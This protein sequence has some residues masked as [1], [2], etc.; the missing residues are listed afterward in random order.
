MFEIDVDVRWLGPLLADEPFEQE[1]VGLRVDARYAEY[2][3]DRAVCRRPPPLAQN[4]LGPRETDDVKDREE[5]RGVPHCLDELKFMP[6][7]FRHRLGDTFGIPLGRPLPGEP[8]QRRLDA[9]ARYDRLLGILVL[10]FAQGKRAAPRDLDGAGERLGVGFEQAVH[11]LGVLEIS[12]GMALAVKTDVVDRLVM[13]DA[14]DD[15]LELATAGFVEK[16]VVGD[17]RADAMPD[18]EVGQVVDAQLVVRPPSQT[19]AH[20]RAILEDFRHLPQLYRACVVGFVRN[21][22]ADEALGIKSDIV[23]IQYAPGLAAARLPE[24]QQAAQARIGR[25]I[26]RIDEER[27]AIGEIE[28]TSDDQLHARRFRCF[29][30]THDPRQRIPVHDPQSLD[31][32]FGRRGEQFVSGTGTSKEGEVRCRLEFDVSHPKIPWRNQRCDPVAVSTP[33]PCR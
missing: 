30:G 25:P 16:G 27:H 32:E 18:S 7:G 20:I 12:V 26:R 10:Q 23:E 24:R 22:D 13:A 19:K 33:S 29:P 2:V 28:A 5:V 1:V 4:S 8:F 9:E 15:V 6:D 31:A 14:G 11:F 3:A 17:D 21:Q